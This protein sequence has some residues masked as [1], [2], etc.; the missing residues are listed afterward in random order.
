MSNECSRPYCDGV[1]VSRGMCAT[2]Y[3]Y[4]Q[5]YKRLR[6]AELILWPNKGHPLATT[7]QV[8][9]I[10]GFSFRQIDYMVRHQ[11]FETV[12]AG[13]GSG[14]KR[15][16]SVPDV[17]H[18]LELYTRSKFPDELNDIDGIDLIVDERMLTDWVISRWPIDAYYGWDGSLP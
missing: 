14:Y 7:K 9:E 1:V 11:W 10:T 12:V 4:F 13:E 18:M 3:S 8:C 5:T 2:C 6:P 17:V 16:W 15:G